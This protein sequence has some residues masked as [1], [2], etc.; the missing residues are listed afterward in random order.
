[1]TAGTLGHKYLVDK[2]WKC[3][4]ESIGL[5]LGLIPHTRVRVQTTARHHHHLPKPTTPASLT[6]L[7]INQTHIP[8]YAYNGEP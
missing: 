7:P 5:K 6:F 3:L 2:Q 1:M 8:S 4:H